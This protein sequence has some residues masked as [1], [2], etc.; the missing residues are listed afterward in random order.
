MLVLI[1]IKQP[2]DPLFLK[3]S[4]RYYYAHYIC[5]I[6]LICLRYIRMCTCLNIYG[7]EIWILLSSKLKLNILLDKMALQ[8]AWFSLALLCLSMLFSAAMAEGRHIGYDPIRRGA[9]PCNKEN[10][11]NCR[12][13]APVNPRTRPC[14]KAY[15]CRSPPPASLPNANARANVSH[16]ESH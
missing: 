9:I 15:G 7:G 1:I 6:N 2:L 13:G 4:F 5:L 3:Y 16:H 12:P 14:Y 8:R 11:K 10:K